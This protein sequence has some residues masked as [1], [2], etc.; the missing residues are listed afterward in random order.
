MIETMC[1]GKFI[2][3]RKIVDPENHVNG[4]EFVHETRCDGKIISILP[5]RKEK[6]TFQI[7]LRKE[8][9]PCWIMNQQVLS[10]I[11]GGFEGG[12][13]RD[14]TILELKEEAG[15]EAQKQELISLGTC[16]GTKS[17]DTIYYLYSID[18]TNREKGEATS[19]GSDLEKLA[20]CEW[21][22][23]IDIVGAKDPLASTLLIRLLI[24]LR[25]L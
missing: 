9:T 21:S 22:S 8:V 24:H 5:Y 18:L 3:L 13:P 19:D 7:L 12:D 2:S 25:Q 4:Y 23:V 6:D 20:H 11:T 1:D 10:S 17:S 15:Y 16:F 14:T